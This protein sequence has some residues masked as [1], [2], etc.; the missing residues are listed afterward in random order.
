MPFGLRDTLATKYILEKHG[1]CLML[2]KH[3]NSVGM[4][5]KKDLKL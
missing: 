4:F 2:Q 5:Q 1:Y 3:A